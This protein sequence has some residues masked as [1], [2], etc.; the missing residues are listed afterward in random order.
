MADDTT[1]ISD[2]PPPDA[3][4]SAAPTHDISDLPPPPTG[5]LTTVGHA[6]ED[7]AGGVA[8]GI[9]AAAD[10]ATNAYN[11]VTGSNDAPT[12]YREDFQ[13]PFQHDP[14]VTADP[15]EGLKPGVKAALQKL[16]A[17]PQSFGISSFGEGY[18]KLKQ[19]L[20]DGGPAAETVAKDILQPVEDVAGAAFNVDMAGKGAQAISD[21]GHAVADAGARARTPKLEAPAPTPPPDGSTFGSREN[22]KSSIKSQWEA[23]GGADDAEYNTK[24]KKGSAPAKVEG[25][26]SAAPEASPATPQLTQDVPTAPPGGAVAPEDLPAG[27]QPEHEAEVARRRAEDGLPPEEVP[28]SEFQ[29]RQSDHEGAVARRTADDSVTNEPIQPYQGASPAGRMLQD[30][31]AQNLPDPANPS[32]HVI[33][34]SSQAARGEKPPA[35]GTVKAELYTD[36]TDPNTAHI[37]NLEAERVGSGDGEA[38]L[39]HITKLA[40]Q[41]NVG[42]TLDA[43]PQGNMP[44]AKLESIYKRNG[45]QVVDRT[46]DGIASMRR[47]PA[48]N[49]ASG[50][51][52]FSVVTAER[53]ERT[54][55]ENVAHTTQLRNQLKASGLQ[56][57]PTEGVYQGGTPEKGFAVKTPTDQSKTL[58]EKLAA[59]HDQESVLHVD[60]DR[61][62]VFKYMADGREEPMGKFEA[63]SPEDAQKQI[64]YTRDANGQHYVLRHGEPE[65][66]PLSGLPQKP[67]TIDGK[68]VTP[69]PSPAIR[70][71]ADDYMKQTG[72]EY[73]KPTDYK[74]ADP[75]ELTKIAADYDKMPHNP[76]DPAVKASY[77]ALT[78]ETLA[79]WQA[80]KKSGLKVDFI[81]P[82]Q[83]DPYAASPRLAIE[84]AQKNNHMWV[85]PTESGFGTESAA[86][87]DHPLL[88]D[89]GEKINGQPATVNDI[90][91]IVHDYFGHAAEGNG[92]RADG[93]FNAWRLHNAMYSPAA[94][95]ALASETLGQNAWVNYGPHGEANRTASSAN[96]KFADQKAGLMSTMTQQ[97]KPVAA[98][99]R[100][101]RFMA[102][103]PVSFMRPAD[104]GAVAGPRT[105]A[106][107]AQRLQTLQKIPGLH[108]KQ[109]RLS[110]ITGDTKETGTDWATG[111][112][113]SP[114][115]DLMTNTVGDERQAIRDNWNRL[116]EGT[117]GPI[118][119]ELSDF[120]K[121]GQ[122]IGGAADAG[123][124]HLENVKDALYDEARARAADK[125]TSLEGVKDYISNNKAEFLKNPEGKQLLEGLNQKMKDL[126]FNGKSDEFN[127]ASVDE[128]ED[129]RKYLKSAYTRPL[130]PII[131]DLTRRLDD[132]VMRSAGEDLFKAGRAVNTKIAAHF[133]EPDLMRDVQTPGGQGNRLGL[134]R[135]VPVEAIPQH[136]ADAPFDQFSHYIDTMHN[137]ASDDRAYPPEVQEKAVDA[138]GAVR[139][140]FLSDIVAAGSKTAGHFNEKAVH[141]ILTDN[142]DKL[143]KIF[144]PADMQQLKDA[145]DAGA[146]LR[147]DKTYKGAG[148]ETHNYI[149]GGL[150]KGL[151]NLGPAVGGMLGAADG[152]ALSSGLGMAAGKMTGKLASK[153]TD[154]SALNNV[155]KR[156]VNI[157]NPDGTPK[158]LSDIIPPGQRGSIS[159]KEADPER[160]APQASRNKQRGGSFKPQLPGIISKN[161]TE[162]ERNQL[163]ADTI[164]RVTDAF[165]ELPDTKEIAAA[166]LAGNAKRGWYKEATQAIGNVFG[167][168]APRFTALL[169]AMSPQTSVE[170][171]FHNALRTFV[172][173]DNAGRP[174]NPT[175]IHGIMG[176][177]VL[178]NNKTDSVLDAWK[179]NSVRALTAEDPEKLTISGPK[180]NSFMRNLHGAMGEVTLDAWMASFANLDA[181]KLKGALNKAGDAPGKS[182]T[183][184]GYSAKVRQAADMVS[185]LTGEKWTPAEVQ[186]TVWSWA[187]SAYEHADAQGGMAT[188]PELVKNKEITDELV[189][190]TSDFH[191]LFNDY[192]H[193][194]V[195]RGSKF[196][197]GLDKLSTAQ[198]SAPGPR[199]ASEAVTAA[200]KTLEPHLNAAAE[201][202]E[203]VRQRRA[204]EK[205]GTGPIDPDHIPGFEDVESPRRG[206]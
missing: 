147:M 127:P 93:E 81:K 199:A 185:K 47:E 111:K 95:P 69:A 53:G 142:N 104:E 24:P 61:N 13:K 50:N 110:A 33:D 82:G 117:G 85:Y 71:V 161:L 139:A 177:S 135:S 179:N 109:V 138:L 28:A 188:I 196:A 158:K 64:S 183:Y 178:G 30:F 32:G 190:G 150:A 41:R 29:G 44:A 143:R 102:K 122:L 89:S 100:P 181:G 204:A 201:R 156:L 10:V 163:R 197:G 60:K 65:A 203:Q 136:V 200:S 54:P 166:A 23:Q 79:Q 20:L 194:S 16:D 21:V 35:R 126:G 72:L 180:V 75:K 149:A 57:Q 98:A 80:I 87:K 152:G 108:G 133:E 59:K 101:E 124:Q 83:P 96:T 5:F 140:Q 39:Q 62:G 169:A 88:K 154:A 176:D 118:G 37:Q 172:N 58:V 107:Q 202:L 162:P 2:L 3:S 141:K 146:I 113:T 63:T 186:E 9:G 182:A 48:Q 4:A 7:M 167:A 73:N 159:L 42:L 36:P 144:N 90:F 40:D 99:P 106:E 112:L 12:N 14:D 43:K 120:R 129:L 145:N 174:K 56:P 160:G 19:K 114:G 193:S 130:A 31:N 91:R 128:A 205:R 115:G 8:K 97:A 121:R 17:D 84:D 168:D 6:A 198:G 49:I 94:R 206:L 191:S 131:G 192:E 157:D 165:K 123:R 77:D 25:A 45:F 134:N 171:N 66:E 195:L 187:K 175:M 34:W 137:L 132:D 105:P 78:K 51:T 116:A 173:W 76:N 1:D 27:R 74:P 68:Q 70:K 148:A 151:E 184:L 92:F 119:A 153:I 46:P 11:A 22:L 15:Y 86:A 26:T 67:I 52:P 103:Q 38:A 18:E 55:E 155:K 170:M 125:P 189:R 164:Q